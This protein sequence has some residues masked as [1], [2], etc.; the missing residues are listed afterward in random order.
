MKTFECQAC[1]QLLN[2]ESTQCMSCGHSLGYLPERTEMS[3]LEPAADG[4]WTALADDAQQYKS[5]ANAAY[6]ACN[7]LVPAQSPDIFCRACRLNRTIP[8]LGVDGNLELWRRLEVAKHRLVYGLMR[9]GLP[10][11]GRTEDPD[12]GLAFD[13]LGDPDHDFREGPNVI[14][15]HAQGLI[16]I[17]IAEADD[18]ARESHRKDMAEPYRTLIGHFRHEVG[19]HYWEKLIRNGWRERFRGMFGDERADYAAALEAHYANGLAP[20]WWQDYVSNYA[21][22][23]PW[24]DFAETWAHY[25]HIVDTLETGMAFGL[26]V[27]PK[28]GSDPTLSVEI[29]FDPYR[30]EDFDTLIRAWLPLTYAVN[31]LNRSMGQPDLYP[32]VLGDAVL[33]KLRFIH[34]LIRES[35]SAE[36]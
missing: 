25:M 29:D 7:W 12:A 19:H 16:T 31:S 2:F 14:T 9:L 17:N 6:D 10:I 26:K 33:A 21:R 3:A 20:T 15:G 23:H 8:A 30:E 11:I 13:F 28:A 24:E 1:G 4:G 5:C 32:F 35:R 36:A 34:D 18:A 27:E 22:S